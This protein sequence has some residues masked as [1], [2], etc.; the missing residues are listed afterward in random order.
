MLVGRS[1]ECAALERLTADARQ[2][3]SATLVLRGEPG[4][5]K[6]ALLRYAADQAKGVTV[7]QARGMESEAELAF[8]GLADLTRPLLGHLPGLPKVQAAALKAALA[9]G[10][11][12]SGD[13]FTIAVATLTLLGAAAERRPLFVI[14]DDAHWLDGP[15][16]EVIG[17][18]ARRL[19]AEGIVLLLALRDGE[20]SSVDVTGL[21]EL[22]VQGLDPVDAEALLRQQ[23]TA[24]IVAGVA[25]QL[26]RATGGNPLA[27][28]EVPS[29]LS[30][31]QL[32]GTVPLEEP[33][34]AGDSIQR[35]FLRRVAKLAKLTLTALL[36]A[37][38]SDSGELSLI[39]TAAGQ[40]GADTTAL[41]AAEAAGLVRLGRLGVEFRHPLLRASIYH[42][43][44][45]QARRDAHRALAT[46]YQQAGDAD[47]AAW[48]L[49]AATITPDPEVA[50]ALEQTG[51]RAQA[52]GGYAAAAHALEHAAQLSP[53]PN[54]RTNRLQ[55]AAEAYWFAGHLDHAIEVLDQALPLTTDARQRAT[56]QHLRGQ[57]EPLRGDMPAA[58]ELLLDAA[59]QIATTDHEKAVLMLADGVMPCISIGR[60]PTA[61]NT[62]RR[63]YKLANDASPATQA[64][65]TI[66]LGVA[67]VCVGQAHE[68]YPLIL[69]SLELLQRE[70]HST[71]RAALAGFGMTTAVWVEDWKQAQQVL[72][73]AIGLARAQSA[74]GMLLPYNL[75]ILS[76]WHFRAGR[77]EEASADAT[78][79]VGLARDTGQLSVLAYNLVCLARVDAARGKEES[80]RANLAEA[81]NLAGLYDIGSIKVHAHATSGLLEL[82]LGRLAEA[83]DRLQLVADLLAPMGLGEPAAV[84]WAP[85]YI[86]ACA[87]TGKVEEATKALEAFQH[88]AE[89]TGRTWALAA[90]AR[91]HGLLADPSDAETVFAEAYRWH[92]HTTMPF[93]LA[94]TQLCHGQQLRRAK[95]R[96]AARERL[97][98]ALAT[99]EQLGARP[100]A[101]QARAELQATGET[102]RRRAQP[103]TSRLTPQEFQVARLVAEGRSN[104]DIAAALFLSPK[105]VEFH[106]GSIHR[107]LGT[108]SRPQLVHLLLQRANREHSGDV[109]A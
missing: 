67:L 63:A 108:S 23:H 52:R 61:L 83:I 85:D 106:L 50:Q 20:V 5:G 38:A 15:S 97:R 100:W 107:K 88:Q 37:A 103:A 60:I 77:W 74:P 45:P 104:R 98:T 32:A 18:V 51:L 2:G 95:Q 27:L 10:P 55:G 35:A 42:G 73:H 58:Y 94:R 101:D 69:R 53:D 79:G 80:C 3:R 4:I 9:L 96:T 29:L 7:V 40:L 30:P 43:A 11:P 102:A 1:A 81:L 65:A 25:A 92:Q 19:Q 57:I 12:V 34:P 47:R 14:V 93:E 54:Q 109:P 13:R 70:G 22:A 66:A 41:E 16:A 17:F 6:S 87:R 62:A 49:A 99:F 82:G 39:A 44:T 8:S 78:E 59:E 84:Q 36:V 56:L 76:D 91:C 68:G 105:T 48:Q 31:E 86:E 26:A 90:T 89:A 46:T 33:L 64:Y 71:L 72:D 24:P 75:G 21:A 28:L